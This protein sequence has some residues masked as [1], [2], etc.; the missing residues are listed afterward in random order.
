MESEEVASEDEEK[1]YVETMK[2]NEITGLHSE[3]QLLKTLLNVGACYPRLVRM[4]KFL[5]G[6][7]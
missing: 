2:Y 7:C 3:A 6:S 1:H 4:K 5:D